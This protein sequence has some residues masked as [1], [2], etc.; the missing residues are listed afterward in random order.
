MRLPLIIFSVILSAACATDEELIAQYKE[1]DDKLFSLIN[2]YRV[3]KKKTA[4]TYDKTT[5]LEMVKHV[6]YMIEKGKISHDDFD[7]RHRTLQYKSPVENVA[8]FMNTA[9]NG[10]DQVANKILTQWINSQGH[11]D[12]MLADDVNVG[13]VSVMV[14]SSMKW[15]SAMF[16]GKKIKL[17][18]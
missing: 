8:S 13:A 14:N 2:A 1:Y 7:D 15:F 12:N 5:H 10:P 16:F 18:V 6:L 4:V 9:I 3:Q 11:N 17:V